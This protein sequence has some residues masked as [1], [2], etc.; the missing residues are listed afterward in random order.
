MR[1]KLILSLLLALGPLSAW[2][3]GGERVTT[4]SS[5]PITAGI[6]Y[7]TAAPA[8]DEPN[9]PFRQALALGSAPE[10]DDLPMIILSHGDGGWMG[11]H[12]DTALALAEA[13]YVAV[14]L[15]HPGN[16]SEDESAT[17]SK[18]L[19]SRPQD[20]SELI[21][22]MLKDWSHADRIDPR[23]IGLYGFSA[24]G[25]TALVAAGATP[26]FGLAAK[27]CASIP[28]EFVCRIGLLDDTEPKILSDRV[29]EVAGD[30]RIA[31]ISVAAPGL[32]FAF[33][34]ADLASVKVPVQIWSGELDERVP[35]DTNGLHLAENLHVDVDMRLVENAGHFAFMAECNLSLK[36]SNRQI[37]D[38]ICV[39]APGFD[40]AAFHQDL[41]KSLID[42]F[43]GALGR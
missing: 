22:F 14:A 24:G 33:S 21:D 11:G 34:E 10:G 39:D 18:W 17:P 2:A 31:A 29:R 25:Y 20:V 13:G 26:D 9:T 30:P 35:H 28:N 40:R 23:K 19:L 4:M 3:A 7:P 15:E 41:N 8:P 37:W 43:D 6:W 32:G 5:P 38:M 12:A 1:A 42:F 16:N 27:H 36:D